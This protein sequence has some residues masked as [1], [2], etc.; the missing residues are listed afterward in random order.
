MR[1]DDDNGRQVMAIAHMTF[2]LGELKK[3]VKIELKIKK[4]RFWLLAPFDPLY[5]GNG[6][7]YIKT[8]DIFAKGIFIRNPKK[9]LEA[10]LS[11]P[12]SLTW[13]PSGFRLVFDL[14]QWF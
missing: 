10:H 3:F 14:K 13:I 6:K 7:S 11:E 8:I 12:V 4:L 2:G 5:L 9:K 1:T